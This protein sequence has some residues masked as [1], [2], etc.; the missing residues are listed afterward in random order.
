[1]QRTVDLN[2]RGDA[3]GPPKSA[4]GNRVVGIPEGLWDDLIDYLGARRDEP[5][6]A[7]FLAPDGRRFS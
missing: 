6:A 1:V 4:A 2:S 7:V 3:V 5:A